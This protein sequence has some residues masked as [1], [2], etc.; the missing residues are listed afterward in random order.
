M[1]VMMENRAISSSRLQR[2][3]VL[4]ALDWYDHHITLGVLDHAHRVGWIL[5]D[6]CGHQGLVP[7][8][9]QGDGVITLVNN[10]MSSLAN[11]VAEQTVPVVDLVCEVPKLKVPRVLADDRAIGRAAAEHLMACGLK[12]LAFFNL[13]SSHVEILRQD[14]FREAVKNAGRRFHAIDF[15]AQPRRLDP[16]R[17]LIPWMCQTLTD[18]PRPIGVMGQHDREASFVVRAA[19]LAGLAVPN[20]VAVVGVDADEVSVMLAPIPLSSVDRRRRAHGY[21]A[22]V[23]LESLMEGEPPPSQPILI[24]PGPVI[25]RQSSDVLAIDDPALRMAIQFI[26]DCFR[27]PIGVQDVV[28]A[29]HVSRRR[30]YELFDEHLGHSIRTEIL[31]RRLDRARQ[32]LA[33]SDAKLFSVAQASGFSDAQQLARVFRKHVGMTPGE[34]RASK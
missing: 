28:E 31:R 6:V 23:L 33:S 13:A 34:Y 32:L 16:H 18:L 30:L 27:D 15:M 29:T 7:R 20:E 22:A 24:P 9:W 17:E 14:G 8:Q 26:A 10:D 19:E 1:I 5:N 21:E 12:D 3:H 25:P 11:F 4:L 2:K